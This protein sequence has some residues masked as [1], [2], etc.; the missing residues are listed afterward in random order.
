MAETYDFTFIPDSS[1]DAF[2]HE[3]IGK[4]VAEGTTQGR[5]KIGNDEDAKYLVA[6]RQIKSSLFGKLADF[7]DTK[8]HRFVEIKV[9]PKN[10]PILVNV[11]SLAK[12]LDISGKNQS[13]SSTQRSP[14]IGHSTISFVRQSADHLESS[15]S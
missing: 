7:I 11:N 5:L 8:T 4:E 2:T 10:E 14:R 13:E 6:A 1:A 12:R 9:G 3:V 15:T